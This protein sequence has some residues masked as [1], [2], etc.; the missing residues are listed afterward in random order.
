MWML[1]NWIT[2]FIDSSDEKPGSA[3]PSLLVSLNLWENKK[4]KNEK[5]NFNFIL[6][7]RC[8]LF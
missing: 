5:S 8:H 3:D 4:Q 6:P 7:D 2:L 1:K